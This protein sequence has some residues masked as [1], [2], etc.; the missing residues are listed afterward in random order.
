MDKLNRICPIRV[1]DL[2]LVNDLSENYR[3]KT[4]IKMVTT[5]V[6]QLSLILHEQGLESYRTAVEG[7]I[8]SIDDSERFVRKRESSMIQFLINL[9]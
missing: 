1:K 3:Q 7:L 4:G 2:F 8:R 9:I 6:D 5:H